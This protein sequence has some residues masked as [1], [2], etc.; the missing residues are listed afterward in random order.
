MSESANM[1]LLSQDHEEEG[2]GS[3]YL[4]FKLAGEYYG[5]GILQ[6]QEIRGW[7]AATRLPNTPPHLKGVVNLRGNIVPVYDL[8]SWF[9][10]PAAEYTKE[11]VVII[12]RVGHEGERRSMGMVVDEVS[13]VLVAK[14]DQVS[15]T[16]SFNA[17]VPTEFLQGLVSDGDD[18]VMLLDLN[19]LAGSS[20]THHA[21]GMA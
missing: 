10:M 14:D 21:E 13:D 15:A 8:R 4:T 9:G 7:E 3:Q 16:P 17:A 19:S 12:V 11:T 2:Q 18:M 1:G 6:V 20:A 5:V